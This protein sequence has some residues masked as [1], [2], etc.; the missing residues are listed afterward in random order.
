MTQQHPQGPSL[1]G[2]ALAA[3]LA[4]RPAPPPSSAHR[5][6]GS[7]GR[8]FFYLCPPTGPPKA[9]RDPSRSNPRFPSGWG[10]GLGG[11][12]STARL[13]WSPHPHF[14]WPP[15][16][17]QGQPAASEAR[18]PPLPPGHPSLS[19]PYFVRPCSPP[20]R[21]WGALSPAHPTEASLRSQPLRSGRAATGAKSGT[22]ALMRQGT[23][24]LC[25]RNGPLSGPQSPS[26]WNG[27]N[28]LPRTAALGKSPAQPAALAQARLPP[29]EAALWGQQE[30]APRGQWQPSSLLQASSNNVL[31]PHN[32]QKHRPPCPAARQPGGRSALS[33][34]RGPRQAGS[35]APGKAGGLTHGGP[36]GRARPR[37][38]GTP[39]TVLKERDKGNSQDRQT[40]GPRSQAS[41][42]D[43]GQ[44]PLQE[45]TP[46]LHS[47]W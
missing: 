1:T 17:G 15:S 40:G 23:S 7:S 36:R 32:S 2:P 29:P 4:Q 42:G 35:G 14:P 20:R 31:P 8:F 25:H 26:L 22:S 27:E 47:S 6:I 30:A 43:L 13:T 16:G 28:C 24:Q 44:A 45:Q 12:A 33:L 46:A 10:R 37:G 41:G 3:P 19:A 38:L 39:P 34:P 18:S 9:G 21:L 11:K 5:N